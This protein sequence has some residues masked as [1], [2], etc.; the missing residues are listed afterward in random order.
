LEGASKTNFSSL[1]PFLQIIS[2]LG[3]E[4]EASYLVERFVLFLDLFFKFCP[5]FFPPLLLQYHPSIFLSLHLFFPEPSHPLSQLPV[6]VRQ[7]LFFP[8][9]RAN[10]Y[11]YSFSSK[12][13]CILPYYKIFDICKK[14]YS[15]WKLC[16]VKKFLF[17]KVGN[18]STIEFS[19]S[20][21]F[22]RWSAFIRLY[23]IYQIQTWAI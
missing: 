7:S 4:L 12:L 11:L 2:F 10:L 15:L 13:P 8:M 17:Q 23:I 6:F 16:W 22:I 14:I 9:P 20:I 18:L 5:I 21:P 3:V 19:N 1:K